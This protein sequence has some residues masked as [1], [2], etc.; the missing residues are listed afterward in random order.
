MKKEST[1]AETVLEVRSPN[2][3]QR[4][5]SR[6]R[7]VTSRLHHSPISPIHR[8]P[9]NK[10]RSEEGPISVSLQTLW[11]YS[12]PSSSPTF[13]DHLKPRLE[14]TAKEN[15]RPVFVARENSTLR[16]K[17]DRRASDGLAEARKR[18][19]E[20]ASRYMAERAPRP[21]I[22]GNESPATFRS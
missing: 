3:L 22:G 14:R 4:S 13:S 16:R 12:S 8:K 21:P 15:R 7:E 1:Q 18:G 20:V 11:P 6:E 5:K 17:S 9:N 10:N 19:V 2:K